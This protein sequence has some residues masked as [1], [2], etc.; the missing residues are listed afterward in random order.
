MSNDRMR[1]WAIGAV[2]VGL[3]LVLQ[4]H[5]VAALFAGL[6]V[7]ELVHAVA[8]R[9]A[10]GGMGGGR[11]RLLTVGLIASLVIGALA[12]CVIV[13][14]TFL[15]SEATGPG[16]LLGRLA[17]I[18]EAS[19]GSLPGWAT[20]Q[21]PTDA[22]MLQ[23]FLVDWMRDHVGQVRQLGTTVGVTIGHVAFG[24]LIGAM[25]CLRE[26]GR[27]GASTAL[28]D[29]LETRLSLLAHSFR[30][31][32]FAQVKISAINTTMTAVYL[33]VL[34][35]AFG[36]HLPLRKTMIAITFIAGLMPILGNL[37][38]NTLIVIV[39]LSASFAVAAGS[40]T[41]LV[42]L[43]KFEYLL[44]ARII[45]HQVKASAWE[46]LTAMLVAE[47]AFGVPGLIAAPVLY[48]YIKAELKHL[49]LV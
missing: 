13:A 10:F 41:F 6:L 36:I 48:A 12:A 20:S 44:N 34:L 47:T 4:L 38:S 24:A 8:P 35:P 19:R 30:Q 11:A 9:I 29:A 1:N 2:L 21:L 5:L 46:L 32:V 25:I 16:E 40:L 17:D 18:I 15:R 27:P 43:H 31:V 49:G 37:V 23:K 39:S 45:G 42:L 33:I 26:A 28:V 3:L 22:G 14:F 7:H